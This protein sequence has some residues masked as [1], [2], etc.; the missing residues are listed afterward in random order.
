MVYSMYIQLH[1][2][3]LTRLL[4]AVDTVDETNYSVSFVLNRTFTQRLQLRSSY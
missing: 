2:G 3:Y 4:A 1:G